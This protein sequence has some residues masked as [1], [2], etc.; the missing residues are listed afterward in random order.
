[1]NFSENLAAKAYNG[2]RVMLSQSLALW[3]PLVFM[4]HLSE[5]RPFFREPRGFP[6]SS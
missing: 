2:R 4:Q 6:N 3:Q 5:A 1:M